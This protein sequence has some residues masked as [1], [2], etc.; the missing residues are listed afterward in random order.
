MSQA[1]PRIAV[2]GRVLILPLLLALTATGAPQAR[3]N[4]LLIMVDT[5]RADHV[6]CYG[7]KLPTTP[8]IDGVAAE[9]IRFAETVAAASWTMPSLATMFTGVPP[10]MHQVT[11]PKS[12]MSERLTTLAAELKKV[13]Y[14]TAGVT[15]NPMG[16]RTFG[17]GRGFDFY[18]DF[19][20]FLGADLDLFGD[21]QQG[22]SVNQTM[23]SDAVNR[24][25]LNWL[26][27][28]RA[29]ARPFFLF[30]LYFD[31]HADYVP[32]QEYAERFTDPNY[33]GSQTGLKIDALRG[34]PLPPEDIRYLT[35]LY[36]AEVRYTDDR[37]ARVVQTLK[38][39][40]LYDRTLVVIISD[41]GEEFWEHGSCAHGST[42]YDECVMVPWIMRLPRSLPTGK[43]FDRQV[44]HQ[45]LMPTIL[46]LVGC[47]VPAQCTGRDLSRAIVSGTSPASAEIPAF[48]DVQADARITGARTHSQKVL[49]YSN[50]GK[51]ELFALGDD[52]REKHNLT[53]TETARA[54]SEL[55]GD[56]DRWEEALPAPAGGRATPAE[57]QLDPVLLRQLRSIGYVR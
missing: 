17:F 55:I 14:Q 40:H 6:G 37:I 52:P 47:K 54:F 20:V 31:P 41:H 15:S 22:R 34:K 1:F 50:A 33:Q 25:A 7:Y 9:G 43:V 45:D 8:A 36:D 21:G 26:A 4:I 16:S 28:K 13:G 35:G 5:L 2:S 30:L 53:G 44:S 18:D 12:L 39:G 27:Q 19:T 48:M 32:P 51:V 42:L 11:G 49:R 29:P 46:G 23:T 56:L 38:D 3:P 57:A 10:A 24:V